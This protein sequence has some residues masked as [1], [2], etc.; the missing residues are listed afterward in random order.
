M[1]ELKRINIPF[2]IELSMVVRKSKFQWSARALKKLD[3]TIG[4]DFF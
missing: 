2:S 4:S 3:F 1:D